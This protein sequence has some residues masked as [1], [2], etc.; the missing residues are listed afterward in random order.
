MSDKNAIYDNKID[1]LKEK[2]DSINDYGEK[3]ANE[4]QRQLNII[5]RLRLED[6]A[7][8]DALTKMEQQVRQHY[9][10]DFAENVEKPMQDA[11]NEW[12]ETKREIHESI[13]ETRDAKDQLGEAKSISEIGEEAIGEAEGKLDNS[14]HDYEE[15][16]N[17]LDS[18]MSNQNSRI[19]TTRNRINY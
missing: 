5:S 9:R 14:I 2:S 13:I 19:S 4:K 8:Q 10:D 3:R 18:I 6:G 1:M 16:A 17:N 12:T 11:N 15:Q 7:D